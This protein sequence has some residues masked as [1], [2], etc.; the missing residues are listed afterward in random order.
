MDYTG[1]QRIIPVM[2]RELTFFNQRCRDWT[3]PYPYRPGDGAN[4]SNSG[5]GIFSLCHC[6][7]WL[8]GH[9]PDPEEVAD[10][11]CAFGGRGDDGTDRPGLLHAVMAQGRSAA[12]GFL[13]REDGLLNDREALWQMLS[14]G[15]GVAMC[16]LR[17]GHIVSLVAA[18][19]Q[20]GERQLL[21]IDSYSE[22]ADERVR[23][24][25]RELIPGTEILWPVRNEAGLVT[26]A[27]LSSAAFWVS[28]DTPADF[29][30]MWAR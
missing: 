13:Y 11:S 3:H 6:V 4:L 19:E 29:N 2:G 12:Y 8:T 28:A 9:T 15:Q 10:F 20:A 22:S 30:L 5:C 27:G 7:Q 23:N 1:K 24:R 21:A 14:R 18:R 25:V 17:V 26:G 16:N